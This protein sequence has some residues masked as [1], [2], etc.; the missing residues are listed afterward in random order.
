MIHYFKLLR[1]FVIINYNIIID[2][3]KKNTTTQGF[4]EGNYKYSLV[5]RSRIR[6]N[7]LKDTTG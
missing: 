6:F 3:I 2:E 4:N 7:H 1:L 5:E